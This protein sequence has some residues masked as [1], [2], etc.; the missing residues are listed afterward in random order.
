VRRR[1]AHPRRAARRRPR[2]PGRGAV[3]R[4]GPGRAAGGAGRGERDGRCRG[5]RRPPA[6]RRPADRPPPRAPPGPPR[7]A[8]GTDG[9]PPSRRRPGDRPLPRAPS[10]PPR[11]AQGTDGGRTSRRPHGRGPAVRERAAAVRGVLLAGVPLRARP[12]G[13]ARARTSKGPGPSTGPLRFPP[14]SEPLDPPRVPSQ[15]SANTY[16]PRGGGRV[17]RLR[18][19]NAPTTGNGLGFAV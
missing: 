7:A 18:E 10:G 6:R 12:P 1:H 2:L 16:D 15:Q 13:G 9:R 17:A 4:G 3:V 19:K 14:P 5:P 8:P 11:A